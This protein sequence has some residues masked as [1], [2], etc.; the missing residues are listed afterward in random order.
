M[1]TQ[2]DLDL[3]VRDLKG[4]TPLQASALLVAVVAL[5]GAALIWACVTEVDDVTRAPGRVVPAGDVQKVQAAQAGVIRHIYVAEGD[6][7]AA[8]APL[9]ELDALV[10][11]SQLDQ[12]A[13]KAFALQARMARLSA[14]IDGTK[15][16]F[17]ADLQAKAPELLASEQAL[18]DGRAASLQA[19]IAVLTQQREQRRQEQTA[20]RDEI[21]SAGRAQALLAEEMAIVSPLVESGAE[22]RTSL[23]TLQ[24]QQEDAASRLSAAESKLAQLDTALAEVEDQMTA[25]RTKFRSDALRDLSEATAALA[26]LRPTLPAL[27]S[28]A[29]RAVLRA[30]VAGIVNRLQRR[31]LGGSVREGEDVAEIVPLDDALLVEAYVLPK[32]IAFLRPDQPVKVKLTAYEFSRYGALQGKILRIGADAVRRSERDEAE[33]FVVV[34]Q[35]QGALYDADG[36]QAPVIPGMAAEIDILSG[37][38][39][40][41][42]YL[43]QPI[44]RVRDRAFRE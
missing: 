43:L 15:P 17:P 3:L 5:L 4:K 21:G 7:V 32:D 19:D 18:Y 31:T 6:T 13:Q 28:M 20:A 44:E 35:T 1:S 36:K 9:V 12:E 14:E 11:T 30:P 33:V 29:A 25:A 37:H 42:D 41:I 39:R 10:Q 38:H 26:T 40:V 27:Q 16:V 2:R 24:R 23:L 22:P 34:I 8:G